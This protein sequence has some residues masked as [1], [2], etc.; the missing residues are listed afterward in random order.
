VKAL[1]REQVAG[2]KEKAVR[3]VR[4]VLGDE[5]RASEIEDESVEHYAERRKIA[6]T[7]PPGR[8]Q[9]AQPKNPTKQEL[10]DRIDQ[11]EQENQDLSDQLDA[12]ADIVSPDDEADDDNGD[13]DSD[14]SDGDD[15]D[16][17][18]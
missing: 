7:N 12:I 2:R 1:T 3:F 18:D 9:M 13:D 6:I 16:N 14:D 5:D 10:L 11:L 8:D 17:G 4:D 15:D